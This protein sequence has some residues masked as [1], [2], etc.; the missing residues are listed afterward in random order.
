M[1]GQFGPD[2][3]CEICAQEQSSFLFVPQSIS[4]PCAELLWMAGLG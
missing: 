1:V 4:F 2:Q 3:V